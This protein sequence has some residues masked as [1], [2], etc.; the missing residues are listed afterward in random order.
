MKIAVLGSGM[1][2]RAL[3]AKLADRGHDVAMGTR[4][5]KALLERSE[6][7]RDGKVLSFS[8]WLRDHESVELATFGDAAGPAEILF[9]A[10][11]GAVS[12]DALNLAG[13]EN[14][15]DK[16]LVDVSNP[17]DFSRGMPPSLLVGS[18]ESLAE[19][20][21]AAFPGARVVK[22]LNTVNAAVMVDPAAVAGGDHNIFLSGDDDSAKQRVQEIL[23][24]DFGWRHVIDLGALST[25]RAAE[26]W[27]LMWVSL[28]SVQ[29]TAMFNIK[30]MR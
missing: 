1:V 11:A 20:I 2:G 10:T 17:L 13:A 12:L 7:G 15:A 19:R 18:T 25:A 27:L 24:N 21:Q 6:T 23:Q 9:N 3:S 26:H 16:I 28:L 4:D 30:V 14:L 5:V 8:D 22:T 29:G